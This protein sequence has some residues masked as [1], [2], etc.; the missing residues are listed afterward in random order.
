MPDMTVSK[1]L[2]ALVLSVTLAAQGDV[3]EQIRRLH[4]EKDDADI[5]LIAEIGKS[6]SR[7]AAVG[8]IEGYDKCV[9]LLFR[10]EIVKVLARFANLPA[11]EQPVLDKLAEIA[12]STEED[13]LRTLSLRGLG[14]STSIGKQLLQRI[15]DSNAS[16]ELRVPAMIEH[17][18]I[19][20]AGDASWYRKIWNLE[21][22]QRKDE[23][24]D[25]L[26]PEHNQIRQLA[27][28]GAQQFLSQEEL[29]QTLKREADPKIR[30]SALEWMDR[31]KMPKA[32]SMA[33][34]VLGRVTFRGAERA[35][36]ARMLADAKGSKVIADF[37]KLAKKRD[38]TQE[39]LRRE[40][41][42]LI[43]IFGDPKSK[44]RV[45]K[46]IGKGKPHEKIFAL[47]AA[48]KNNDPKVLIA[49]RKC[50][51]DRSVEVRRAAGEV[52]GL[53]RDKAS[54]PA[55]RQLLSKPKKPEDVRIALEAI[56]QIEGPVSSWL[57]ELAGYAA[58]E[59]RDVRN[60][61]MAVLGAARDKRQLPV[62]LT[63][64]EH[65]DWSTRLLAI[66]AL[67][68]L[69]DASAVGKLI[70]R[71]GMEAGRIKKEVAQALWLLTAQPFDEDE[72]K[73]AGWW[74]VAKKDFKVATADELEEAGKARERR[75]LTQRTV[76]KAKFF[77]I[78]VESH[79]VIFV[80]DVSGSM[81]ES[82]YGRTINGRGA[83][84][85]DIAKQELAQAVDNLDPGALFNIFTFSTGVA[86][87][88]KAGIGSSSDSSRKDAKDWIERLGAAGGTNLYD[89]VREALR[90]QDVDT[91]FILSDGEPTT[92][93][94]I[95]PHRIREDVVRW[96]KHRK[97]MIH[98]IA[99]GGNLEILEWL[100][101]DAGGKYRQMR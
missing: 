75:R 17:V 24:G 11:S 7:D 47:L 95:D 13:E 41:A 55:L 50:L 5:V 73:W 10:R 66:Q 90:D 58:N 61:A 18:K 94:V 87:W 20:A 3:T 1:L 57:T 80:L 46:M 100:A 99:I 53:R 97:V 32:I 43:T 23:N 4:R 22:K 16:D 98:T 30:R 19:A 82:M 64:L 49:V 36:A 40:M 69:R 52:L 54:L 35:V 42:R 86:R 28:Q 2:S 89:S 15:I 81:M 96:N 85:I 83:A 77:G 76:S 27:F 21:N 68:A 62:L 12:G 84:R 45:A 88:L 72:D 33:E 34:M 29:I 56:D 48:A 26:P 92:G 91:I 9:T 59:D 79:R 60:A 67:A 70:E 78:K 14:Q 101:A 37:V 25:I 51:K 63:A 71:I 65:S 6:R 38:V 31:E 74:R 93:D 39:D 8:L 44:Q